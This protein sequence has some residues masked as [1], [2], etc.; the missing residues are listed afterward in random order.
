MAKKKLSIEDEDNAYRDAEMIKEQILFL[1]S[2]MLDLFLDIEGDL[3]KAGK[4]QCKAVDRLKAKILF[5]KKRMDNAYKSLATFKKNLTNGDG[6]KKMFVD[7]D[8]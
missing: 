8:I 6:Y 5:G 7:I 3:D 4:L 2:E 1:K